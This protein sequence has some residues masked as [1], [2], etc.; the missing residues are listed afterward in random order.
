MVGGK[1]RKGGTPPKTTKTPKTAG[2]VS[3]RIRRTVNTVKKVHGDDSEKK[4]VDSS[5]T[6]STEGGGVTDVSSESEEEKACDSR[7]PQTSWKKAGRKGKTAKEVR[8]ICKGGDDTCNQAFKEGEL[9]IECDGCKNWYHPECQGLTRGAFDAITEHELFWLCILCR[10]HFSEA[11]SFKT[12]VKKEL[13]ETETRIGRKV[14]EVKVLVEKVIDAKVNEGMKKVEVRIGESSTALK[15]VVQEQYLDRSKNLIL[16]NLPES[17]SEDPKARKEHD[18]TEIGKLVGALGGSE[19]VKVTECFRLYR[20]KDANE[21]EV[22]TRPRL[23]MVKLGKEAE[24]EFLLRKR[25]ELREAGYPNVYISKDMSRD[26]REKQRKLREELA[27]VGR[28]KHKIF[29][30]R[31]VPRGD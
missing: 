15:K 6:D 23:L 24:A 28:D 31:V 27:K 22:D 11:Q 26:E 13:S 29:R 5:V 16:H 25:F 17:L 18:M 30:G 2:K 3:G 12:H 4:V 20:R 7:A 19:N 14:E 9:S 1:Q 8:N 21:G 10:K